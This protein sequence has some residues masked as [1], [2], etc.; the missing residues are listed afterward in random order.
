[1]G[2]ATARDA[3]VLPVDFSVLAGGHVLVGGVINWFQ[4]YARRGRLVRHE[5]DDGRVLLDLPG[6]VR[7]Y[8]GAGVLLGK[9]D[10]QYEWLYECLARLWVV[11]QVPDMADLPLVV[12]SELTTDRLAM[13]TY[14][15]VSEERLLRLADDQSLQ[16]RELHIPSLPT[17]GDWISPLALQFLRRRLR[18]GHMANCLRRYFLSRDGLADRRLSNESDL[19][20][21]LNEYDF[22]IVKIAEKSPLELIDLLCDAQCV[23]GIDDDSMANLL[24]C[25]QGA[26]IGIIATA[27]TYRARAY[28][29]CSQL[30]QEL[31][32]LV[33]ETV[34]ES[35]TVHSLCDIQL[36]ETTLRRFLG[37][38]D[39]RAT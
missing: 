9:A 37:E 35:N 15:D 24:V 18:K 25:P 6:P 36:P 30:A 33:G 26:R 27:G 22:E 5:T 20:A 29:V 4:H 14:F 39:G 17:V 13:L 32:Y 3:E 23:I 7:K 38:L 21:M 19:M 10:D 12:S 28:F 11:E 2:Y 1:L 34:Y 31:T 8:D 16:V